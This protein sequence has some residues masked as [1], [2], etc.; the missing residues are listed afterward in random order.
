[1]P[2]LFSESMIQLRYDTLLHYE[3]PVY[4]DKYS[5]LHY[6]K[7]CQNFK[8]AK[9]YS[10][11]ITCHTKKRISRAINIMLQS[12]EKQ[13]IFNP[14]TKK[15]EVFKL[16]FI[17]L[18]ISGKERRVTPKEG[19]A[20]LL[21]PF[22]QWLTKTKN[23]HTYI[24][25]AELQKNG[26]LHYHISTSTWIHHSEIRNKWNYLLAKAGLLD[27]YAATHNHTNA[28]S[29]DVHKVYKIRNIC[30][31]LHKELCKNIQGMENY[32]TMLTNKKIVELEKKGSTDIN[33]IAITD[34]I[35]K[36]Y[37][38]KVWDCSTNLKGQ[39]YYTVYFDEAHERLL[40]EASK[41]M[42][43]D[44]IRFDQFTLIRGNKNLTKMMLTSQEK[45]QYTAWLLS[46]RK[47]HLLEF[48]VAN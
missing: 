36:E 1:M 10:G 37:S 47:Q 32:I 19:Y 40:Y 48:K 21:K 3:Q 9:T 4:D 34:N 31:Y 8:K 20:I 15:R 42:E 12:L 2:Y 11:I 26:Q 6:N 27:Q 44:E 28:N 24:W 14:I 16:N 13:K 39:K 25:K 46:I 23:V 18:T 22:M 7:M 45:E 35:I 41:K 30:A 17:T 33:R 29:T 5:K 38:G 43:L